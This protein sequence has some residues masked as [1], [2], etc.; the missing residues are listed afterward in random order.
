VELK[1]EVL[2]NSSFSLLKGD[3]AGFM[4]L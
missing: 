2:G 1:P 4:L 3:Y